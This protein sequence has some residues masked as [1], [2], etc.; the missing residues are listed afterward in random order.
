MDTFTLQS[1]RFNRLW[2]QCWLLFINGHISKKATENFETPS[3]SKRLG[4]VCG[5]YFSF[6]LEFGYEYISTDRSYLVRTVSKIGFSVQ[7]RP[8]NTT[9]AKEAHIYCTAGAT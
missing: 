2:Q 5:F 3:Y 7:D 8:Y 9:V 6:Y 4:A 1:L